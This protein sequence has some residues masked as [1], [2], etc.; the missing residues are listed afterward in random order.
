MSFFLSSCLRWLKQFNYESQ[1]CEWHFHRLQ[2]MPFFNWLQWVFF[3]WK[4][5]FH[6][7]C[8]HPP[9]S[10]IHACQSLIAYRPLVSN[11]FCLLFGIQRGLSC[12]LRYP[13]FPTEMSAAVW[14]DLYRP[15]FELC[16]NTLNK[17]SFLLSNGALKWKIIQNTKS[18]AL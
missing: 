7:H 14:W 4:C 6:Y 15:H 17:R 10:V 18:K 13:I 3:L 2:F 9:V 11:F 12:S 5:N 1:R 16:A 8:L